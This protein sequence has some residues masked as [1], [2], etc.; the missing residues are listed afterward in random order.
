MT[1]REN[2]TDEARAVPLP[3]TRQEMER[4]GWEQLDVLI[5]S[6]DAYVDHPSFGAALIGRWLT[7]HGFRTGIVAQPRWD[8]PDDVA[9]MGRPRLFAGVTAGCLDSMLAH[10]TAFRKKR[11][12]DAYTPG[13]AAGRRPNRASIA[14]ANVVQR[15]FPGL[16]VVLGGIEAS[17]RRVTHYDF[18]SDG[19]R[20]SIVLDSKTAAVLYGMAETSVLALARALDG[21][22]APD[23]AALRGILARIPGAA[24]AGGKADIP[25]DAEVLE[26]PSHQALLEKPALLVEATKIL[27]RQVHQDTH[28]ATQAAGDRLVILTPPGPGLGRAGLDLLSTLPF[29]RRPHPA[30][31]ES[32][33][34]ADMIRDSVTTHRGC[35]GGCAFCTLALHQGRRLRSRSRDSVLE[36]VERIVETPGFSGSVTDVGGPSANM[37]GARCL[38]DPA[39]CLRPSC[40]TPARCRHFAVDQGAFVRLLRAVARVPGVRHVRVASGW[41][42]DLALDDRAALGVMIR[43]FVGGQVKVAP[44]HCAA[45]VLKLMRKPGFSVFERFLEEFEAQSR[46]AGKRQFIVPYLMSAHPGCTE[47]HMRELADWLKAQGWKPS[48]VQCFIPLPGTAAAA[49]YVAGTDMEGRP[50]HVARTDAER[51]RQ[52]GML[53]P[54]AGRSRR[55]R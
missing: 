32:V 28:F 40:L 29:T 37:W 42:M 25:D 4:L 11:S 9:R 52:H 54:S 33:P 13:G 8:V 5:V 19:L 7:H 46:K 15:A 45:P 49:M 53:A 30:Y 48:Q 31:A 44:E 21:A 35:A 50:I 12:E 36:E 20:R 1:R 3:M 14:Y 16:P 17:L 55:G 6:G 23:P 38:A 22:G 2:G 24:F 10:Y 27:E 34:A 41:R 51:L 47:G 39:Q 26:L 18:W 43:E